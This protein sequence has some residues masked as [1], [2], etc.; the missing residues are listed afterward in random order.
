MELL[1]GGDNPICRMIEGGGRSL[2]GEGLCGGEEI[3]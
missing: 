1:V 3:F 2:L